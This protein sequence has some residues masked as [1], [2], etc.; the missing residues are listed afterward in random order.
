MNSNFEDIINR[1]LER[2]LGDSAG[3]E[4]CC[5]AHPGFE[6]EL[7]PLLELALSGREALRAD[8]PAAAREITRE[9]LMAH[10]R[11]I[12]RS[13]SSGGARRLR[14]S[15]ARRLFLRPFA[16]AAGLLVLLF[17]GTAVAA[18]GAGPDSILYPVKQRLE[19]ARTALAV[20]EL[21][22]AWVEVGHAN[23]RLDELEKMAGENRQEYVTDL[24]A[25]YNQHLNDAVGHAETA[26]ADGEDT[27]EINAMIQSTRERR[28][29]ILRSMQIKDPEAGTIAP[30]APKGEA[31]GNGGMTAGEPG[32]ASSDES[33][34]AMQPAA[35]GAGEMESPGGGSPG[36]VDHH[37]SNAGG[38]EQPE[39]GNNMPG[40]GS[41]SM[42]DGDGGAH[43]EQPSP[44]QHSTEMPSQEESHMETPHASSVS[45]AG[46][47]APMH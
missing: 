24:L 25:R 14:A 3:I 28:T 32:G 19:D 4:E 31:G 23:A 10:A 17:A 15:G 38:N 45:G 35:G 46:A 47:A 33:G 39:P 9:K 18:T 6:G 22:R 12:S 13:R 43:N 1:E 27:R 41:G 20:Q 11:S 40:G 2:V 26:A 37:D 21:D 34:G 8:I 36:G 44:E 5:A 42:S 16:L 29:D 7:R 30:R